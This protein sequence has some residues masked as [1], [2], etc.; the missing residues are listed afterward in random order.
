[1]RRLAP[2]ALVA[3]TCLLAP[4]TGAADDLFSEFAVESVF[5]T[6]VSSS[7]TT[8]QEKNASSPRVTGA[9]QL[10]SL[11][12]TAGYKPERIDGKAV[13]V[14]VAHGE[15]TIPTTLRA[16][17][18][19]GQI[20]LTMGLATPKKAADLGGEKL[21]KLLSGSPDGGGSY[22]AYDSDLGQIQLRK[23]VSARGISSG[24]LNRLLTEMAEIA[25]SR[26]SSWYEIPKQ[27]ASSTPSPTK[28]AGAPSLTG[29]WVATLASGEA[30]AIRLTQGGRFSL[31]HVKSGR[32]T[33][34]T[35][36]VQRAGSRLSLIG[37]S[38]V[39]IQGVLSNQTGQGFNLTLT[40]GRKLAF[41]RA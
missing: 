30:F 2:L 34:S 6:S 33:T 37:S 38:G 18:G 25:A 12:R 39:T 28:A 17:I 3:L 35:G 26:E 1:M 11:L 9:G 13:R 40:G 22:F 15:W 14:T 7:S 10:G 24:G 29:S 41:K 20:E 32:T 27:E 31:A 5:A 19:R 23:A 16:D 36:Q 8:N 21:L 4:K